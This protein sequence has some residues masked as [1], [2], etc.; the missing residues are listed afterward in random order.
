MSL[1]GLDVGTTGC[2]V[3]IFSETGEV[4]ASAYREY[5]LI[6]QN[7]CYEINP[8]ILSDQCLNT[9]KE[10]AF[11][12]KDSNPVEAISVCSLGESFVPVSKNGEFLDNAIVYMDSRGTEESIW[13]SKEFGDEK[14]F[15][16]TGTPNSSAYSICKLLWYKNNKRYV[17]ESTYKILLI[18]SFILHQL[19]VD[20][21]ISYP[22]ASRTMVF[23]V[24]KKIW[25]DEILDFCGI[26][27]K[28]FPEAVPYGQFIGY[29]DE[30]I[31]KDINLQK[32]VKVFGG[33]H[34]QVACTVVAGVFEE[35][36]AL[37]SIGTLEA[38]GMISNMF[39]NKKIL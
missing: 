32:R 31:A 26:N 22:L 29:V 13:L 8:K 34:D 17:L 20:F 23:D 24:Q 14:L 11:L 16:I 35:T 10:A 5:N 15:A 28:L 33:A 6:M 9:I 7:N 18:E 19:G 2:K 36:K 37:N 21:Y 30:N 39:L 4:I 27:K 12:V 25:S 1:L 38:V 3:M